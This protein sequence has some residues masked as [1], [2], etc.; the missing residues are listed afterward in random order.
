MK[1]NGPLLTRKGQ[2]CVCIWG[3]IGSAGSQGHQ[4]VEVDAIL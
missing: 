3:L 4:A 2:I 1:H